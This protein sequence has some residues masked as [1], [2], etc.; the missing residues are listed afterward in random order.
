M[1][2]VYLLELKKSPAQELIKAAQKLGLGSKEY[3][4]IE[5]G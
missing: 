1:S 2:P 4:L 3:K 5:L